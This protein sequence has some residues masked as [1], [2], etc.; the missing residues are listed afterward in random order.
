MA[1]DGSTAR[2]IVL[3]SEEKYR[4]RKEEVK[5]IYDRRNGICQWRVLRW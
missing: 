1:V 2:R 3:G 5:G 4:W